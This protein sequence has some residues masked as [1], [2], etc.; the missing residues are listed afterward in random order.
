MGAG[1]TGRMSLIAVA[2]T[3]ALV[4]GMVTA[5][6]ARATSEAGDHLP[7]VTSGHRPG[8]DALYLPPPRAPQLENIGPWQADPPPRTPPAVAGPGWGAR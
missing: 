1:R 3:A 2:V 4:A 8:P 6:P 7:S 5:E